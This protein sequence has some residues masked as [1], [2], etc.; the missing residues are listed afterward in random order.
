MENPKNQLAG[1]LKEANNV[2]VT[3][4]TN[5]TVDQLAAAIGLT[6]FL[7]KLK[8]HSTTV[9]S[10]EVPSTIEFLKPEETIETTTDSLRDFIISL[11]KAKADKIRYKV[12]DTMVKIFITP[13]RTSIGEQDLVFGQGDFNVDVVV[14]LG[15]HTKEE[16]DQ[17]ITAHGRI[18]HD[19]TV[20]TLNTQDGSDVGS[21]NWIDK[22]ASSLCEM[23]VALCDL[24][25]TNSLDAQISTALLTGIVAETERFSN[26]KTSSTTMSASAKLMAAGANQQLVATQLQ[27]VLPSDELSDESA[28]SDGQ[29]PDGDQPNDGGSIADDGSLKI[30][31]QELPKP[32]VDDEPAAELPAP[33]APPA[34]EP[35]PPA[36]A[37]ELPA[38]PG[39]EP[40]PEPKPPTGSPIDQIQIS[41]DG[42][43]HLPEEP[44]IHSEHRDFLKSPPSQQSEGFREEHPAAGHSK[45]EDK[46][47]TQPPAFGG[48]LNAS[49]EHGGPANTGLDLPTAGTP[50]LTHGSGPAQK[51]ESAPSPPKPPA[52]AGQ[53]SN[54]P[55]PALPPAPELPEPKVDFP[56]P[57][58]AQ[59]KSPP[60]YKDLDNKTLN[61]IEEKV[62]SSHVPSW[63][64][65]PDAFT[66][67]MDHTTLSGLEEKVDSPH[68]DQPAKE[69]NKK[70]DFHTEAEM[71]VAR[72]LSDK[73]LTDIEEK[74]DSPHLDAPEP[75]AEAKSE[76]KTSALAFEAMDSEPP[77]AGDHKNVDL[78]EAA[79]TDEVD[80]P[81]PGADIE[82]SGE[83]KVEPALETGSAVGSMDNKD[84]VDKIRNRINA[85]LDASDS[86]PQDPL[87]ALGASGRMEVNHSDEPPVPTEPSRQ[88]PKPNIHIDDH[89]E[90]SFQDDPPLVPPPIIPP[91]PTD[92]GQNGS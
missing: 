20:A 57:S 77:E 59:T 84:D 52:S 11:D 45:T 68:L 53:A 86:T 34:D 85:A 42:E 38:E 54:L 60:P 40:G 79:K 91:P 17:A 30:D 16:L 46:R 6:L 62:D 41:N 67:T 5:P 58:A 66:S 25:K 92:N 36:P 48:K 51:D 49:D 50:I 39:P 83:P 64:K 72:A 88:E 29:D 3:V 55:Q 73:T 78:S 10:G 69:D 28:P 87:A 74:V 35:P 76:E 89:G 13:Y 24:L 9:F 65:L 15:V 22:K 31:H 61:D 8:K 21:L 2:L 32:P 23:T 75:A 82:S 27:D 44:K 19:A 1:K 63:K 37:Q 47:I 81:L 12:E 14:G 90:I 80:L 18:L 56:P 71:Q 7:S 70:P 4:S 33:V 26:A 43:L